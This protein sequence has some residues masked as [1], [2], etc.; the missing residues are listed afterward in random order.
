[1]KFKT[2]RY[3]LTICILLCYKL[4]CQ[5]IKSQFDASTLVIEGV[6][7]QTN[8][9]IDPISK[10]IYTDYII[11][12]NQTLKGSP[13]DTK[14]ITLPGGFVD[15]FF[16]IVT[17]QAKLKLSSEGLFFLNE[18]KSSNSLYFKDSK[19]FVDYESFNSDKLKLLKD[20]IVDIMPTFNSD[21]IK[22]YETPLVLNKHLNN[23]LSI[24]SLSPTELSAGT[25]TELIIEGSGFGGFVGTVSFLQSDDGGATQFD[26]KESDIVSW[27]DTKIVVKVPSDAGSGPITVTKQDNTYITSPVSLNVTFNYMRYYLD[28]S[29]GIKRSYPLRHIG[30]MPNNTTASN[31]N[32]GGA[33]RFKMKENFY[34]NMP[35]RN[36]LLDIM[37]E[38]SCK[39]GINFI[40][41]GL[42]SEFDMLETQNLISF[43]DFFENGYGGA[44]FA[45]LSGIYSCGQDEQKQLAV[46]QIDLTFDSNINW[47]Y[48]N[49]ANN[50]FDFKWA[51]SHEIGHG[52]LFGHVID[53]NNLM[54]YAGGYGDR[55][56]NNLQQVYVDA[57]KEKSTF[58]NSFY[59]CGVGMDISTCFSLSANENDSDNIYILVNDNK[60]T[61]NATSSRIIGFYLYDIKG[62]LVDELNFDHKD[63][64][65]YSA[66]GFNRGL[67][68]A[69]VQ[70]IG[71]QHFTKKI[72]L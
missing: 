47:G 13:S 34:N 24:T 54:H 3:L 65:I 39:T 61:V 25:E 28:D 30:Q 5:E 31:H 44:A 16:Q 14:I 62:R 19:N 63:K 20:Q 12:V 26:A 23:T 57:G 59:L 1:M 43:A 17:H 45:S 56:Y 70:L 66:E 42:A 36:L 6:V 21:K 64:F 2:K 27:T 50:Q 8:P 46:T 29:F 60:I 22:S 53:Q 41:E 11:N 15:G 49:V 37:E 52:I 58:S 35:A 67:Y 71:N 32:S 9:Y 18:K 4:N 48:D 33:L 55:N 51:A 7:S 68:F 38:W 40:F 69:Q 72:I 10:N